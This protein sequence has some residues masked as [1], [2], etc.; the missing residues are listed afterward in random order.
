MFYKSK[1]NQLIGD[2]DVSNIENM[3][4][5]FCGVKFNQDISNWK[6]NKNCSIKRAFD[7]CPIEEEFKPKILQS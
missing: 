4:F 1:F 5:M 3:Y 2:W 7:D 6:I